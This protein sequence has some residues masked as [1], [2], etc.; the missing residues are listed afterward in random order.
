MYYETINIEEYFSW[1]NRFIEKKYE[2]SDDE[3]L[4]NP[5]EIMDSD[6][7]KVEKLSYFYKCISDYCDKNYIYPT[8]CNSGNYYKI[9]YKDKGYIVGII[10]GQGAVCFCRKTVI[11]NPLDFIDINDIIYNKTQENVQHINNSLDSISNLVDELYKKGIPINAIKD[12]LNIIINEI[13]NIKQKK[14]L[15]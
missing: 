14:L 4:Y 5:N 3:W 15:K 6:R 1:L 11:D 13:K 9:R 2:F 10:I 8:L 7:K 12:R